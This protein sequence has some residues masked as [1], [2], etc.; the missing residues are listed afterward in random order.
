MKVINAASGSHS[1]E[2]NLMTL[3]RE[4]MAQF[5]DVVNDREFKQLEHKFPNSRVVMYKLSEKIEELE[6]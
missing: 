3:V 5:Y 6:K 2:D 4:E 1:D